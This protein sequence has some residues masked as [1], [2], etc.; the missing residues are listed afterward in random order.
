MKLNAGPGED[1]SRPRPEGRAVHRVAPLFRRQ[2]GQHFGVGLVGS[3]ALV[4]QELDVAAEGQRRDLPA[5]AVLV[6][7][8][9]QHRAEAEREH[10]GLDARPAADDVV[11]VFVNRD[12][13]G[14]R[15]DEGHQ[16]EGQVS[17]NRDQGVHACAFSLSALQG[18]N[19]L[20]GPDTGRLVCLADSVEVNCGA[21]EALR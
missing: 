7:A 12:D 17:E 5:R 1:G 21:V 9:R 14:K 2:L 6:D 18:V 19:R 3:R 16:R 13:D 8:R 4:A 10:L 20:F 11:A 15:D